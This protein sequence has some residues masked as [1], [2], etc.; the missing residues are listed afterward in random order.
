MWTFDQLSTGWQEL[1]FTVAPGAKRLVSVMTYIEPAASAGAFVALVA[2]LDSWIDVEP[3]A[4]G[5]ASGDFSS[6]QSVVDNTEIATFVNPAAGN[7]RI[8]VVPTSAFIF[9]RPVSVCV[10]PSGCVV[11]RAHH[12]LQVGSRYR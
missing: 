7:W 3:F 1:D 8:K 5:G 6:H 2:N 9:P 12:H 10:A 4:D 11:E